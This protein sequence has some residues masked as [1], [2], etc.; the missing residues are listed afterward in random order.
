ML[1]F[2]RRIEYPLKVRRLEQLDELGLNVADFLCF[3]PSALRTSELKK[4]FS[5][6]GSVSC[7]T[8]SDNEDRDFK[9]PVRYEISDVTE[10]MEFARQQNERYFVLLNEAVP[11]ANSQFAGN[12]LFRSPDDFRCEF[13]AG[14]GTPRDVDTRQLTHATQND[15][16][17]YDWLGGL[18]S[19]VRRFP[20][21]PT[22]FEFSVYPYGVGR[23]KE[24]II[25]WEW[26]KV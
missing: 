17:T 21:R 18:V 23:R 24:R 19:S 1:S 16:P 4:F 22:I 3:A 26:R 6:H 13:F 20:Y 15:L 7:R 5:R 9:T 14:P 11:L 10:L 8:F 12:L 25:F 2:H